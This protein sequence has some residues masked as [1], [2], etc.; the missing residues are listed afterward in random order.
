MG[1]HA[2]R[3]QVDN[4]ASNS[5]AGQRASDNLEAQGG[6]SGNLYRGVPT[7]KYDP[8]CNQTIEDITS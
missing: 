7:A 4:L 8:F 2:Q 1:R 5:S 6:A 3:P